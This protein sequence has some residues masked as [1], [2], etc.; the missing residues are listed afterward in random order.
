MHAATC[1]L[2]RPASV[3]QTCARSCV[4]CTGV[5]PRAAAERSK[6]QNKTAKKRQLPV[7]PA[8]ETQA[9]AQPKGQRKAERKGRKPKSNAGIQNPTAQEMEAAFALLNPSGGSVISTHDILQVG[10]SL[11][12]CASLLL[13]AQGCNMPGMHAL[14]VCDSMQASQ[15]G[16][17]LP[18]TYHASSKGAHN[19]LTTMLGSVS[20]GP[21]QLLATAFAMQETAVGQLLGGANMCAINEVCT[22]HVWQFCQAGVAFGYNFD[23]DEVVAMMELAASVTERA[24]LSSMT[25]QGFQK[26][27]EHYSQTA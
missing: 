9:K 19:V 4:S 12:L 6:Q 7:G 5:Q 15:F 14:A 3:H 16:R 17:H 11:K 20:P 1:C 21:P 13:T 10:L 8:N 27:V 23:E 2:P 26:L 25:F 24:S 22:T 18:H